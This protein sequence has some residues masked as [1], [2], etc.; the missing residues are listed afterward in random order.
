GW[1]DYFE[2][3][4]VE[5]KEVSDL[6]GSAQDLTLLLAHVKDDQ[7]L[8]RKQIRALSDVVREQRATYRELA[9]RRCARLTAEGGDGLAKRCQIY[10]DTAGRLESAD[11]KVPSAKSTRAVARARP[12]RVRGSEAPSQTQQRGAGAAAAV[13]SIVSR[14]KSSRR[15]GA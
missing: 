7:R 10:W 15:P 12:V 14:R 9:R 6:L 2:A 13:Q 4:A 8:A 1:P 3:R 11:S 5:A